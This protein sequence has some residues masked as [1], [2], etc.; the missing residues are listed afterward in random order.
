MP[1]WALF[2]Y[3]VNGPTLESRVR[4]IGAWGGLSVEERDDKSTT[5]SNADIFLTAMTS[6][7]KRFD[8]WNDSHAWQK[9]GLPKT[10]L[11]YTSGLLGF[12]AL[13]VPPLAIG[14][15]ILGH[16]GL[17]AAR[18]G[19]ASVRAF[20]L[21]GVGLGYVVIAAWLAFFAFVLLSA[22]T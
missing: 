11:N 6:R 4:E 22:A 17:A 19:E 13:A 15:V 18:R 1:F 12:F 2:R 14:A 7:D 16:L 21:A 10:W 9:S 5:P 8:S 20:G 3:W